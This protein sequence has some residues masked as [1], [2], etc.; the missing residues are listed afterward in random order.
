VGNNEEGNN[1]KEQN[2]Q[3]GSEPNPEKLSFST[4]FDIPEEAFVR[5]SAKGKYTPTINEIDEIVIKGEIKWN[6]LRLLT[7]IK[8]KTISFR[9]THTRM[10]RRDVY[11]S[12]GMAKPKFYDA[13]KGLIEKGYLLEKHDKDD[14][15]FYALNPKTFGGIIVLR[16]VNEAPYRL[17]INEKR[18]S[19]TLKVPTKGTKKV[20]KE[21]QKGTEWVT[22]R[23]PEDTSIARNY[24][25]FEALKYIL[26]KYILLNSI[27]YGTASKVVSLFDHV[28]NPEWVMQQFVK[29]MHKHPA[30]SRGMIEELLRA[31]RDQV[32]ASGRPIKTHPLI[33]LISHWDTVKHHWQNLNHKVDMSEETSTIRE[34]AYQV[35]IGYEAESNVLPFKKV[36]VPQVVALS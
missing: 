25:A 24:S 18:K 35:I 17:N 33:Y 32:D 20:S 10:T 21:Y 26:L 5:T 30:N 27:S 4:A 28:K 23:Y 11:E 31:E 9:N 15:Y 6:E 16:S 12:L 22:K 7:F 2:S 14:Y 36:P 3:Q 19:G 1:V 13:L 34:E 8:G 29:L